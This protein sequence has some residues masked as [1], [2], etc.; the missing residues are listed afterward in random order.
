MDAEALKNILD[1]QRENILMKRAIIDAIF[2]LSKREMHRIVKYDGMPDIEYLFDAIRDLLS[3][4]ED[5]QN[6]LLTNK[7]Q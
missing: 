4:L 7:N 5:G 1:L 6:T 3:S 2:A